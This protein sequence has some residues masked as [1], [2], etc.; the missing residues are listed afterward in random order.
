MLSSCRVVPCATDTPFAVL[1]LERV[2]ETLALEY[3][4]AAK[5]P[6]LIADSNDLASLAKVASQT[7]CVATTVGPY[8]LYGSLLVQAC[9]ETGTSYCDLT[10]ET[11]WHSLMFNRHE[12]Q[13]K[14]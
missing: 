12:R 4:R 5:V 11:S 1:Q 6:I 9:A 8:A 3:P 7:A 10:G 2:R 13:A 14:Q